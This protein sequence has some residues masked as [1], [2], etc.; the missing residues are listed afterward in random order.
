MRSKLTVVTLAVTLT[1]LAVVPGTAAPLAGPCVAG[2]SYDPA[3]DVNHDGVISVLD[4]QLAAGHWNQTG[5]WTSD[6][7]HDHLG[8]TWTGNGGS[9]LKLEGSFGAPDNAPVELSNSAGIGVRVVSAGGSGVHVVSASGGHGVSVGSAGVN[10]VYIHSTVFDGVAINSAGLDGVAINSAGDNGVRVEHAVHHGVLVNNPGWDGLFV[11]SAGDDGIHIA[12]ANDEGVYVG[13][14]GG[15]G[16][17]VHSAYYSGLVVNDAGNDG[18]YVREATNWAG[19]FIGNISVSG[20]C[21]GCRQANF[22]VNADERALQPGD[23][24]AVQA[25]TAAGFDATQFLW[26]VVPAQPGQA[27]VG[28][29]AGR[30][31]LV[32]EEWD[33][34][35][36]DPPAQPGQHLAPRAGAA[37]PGEY[38]AVVYSGP[39]QVRV[40]P[41]E[42][43]IAG[44]TRLTAAADGAVRPLATRTVD[45]MVVSEGAPVLGIALEPA[46]DGVVWVLVNPQ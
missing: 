3:C 46:K 10:G 7:D 44:G 9:G 45:G 13:T 1:L 35:Q 11:E 19:R 36:G 32:A 14:A 20:N 5:T 4:V 24:V 18:V 41:G 22:A 12:N 33:A 25:V 42:E 30:A 26:Q 2:A 43:A 31:E 17:Y 15:D 6:N 23:A 40:A 29:I 27:A 39:M 37:Q 38:L 28:V 8:Q 34:E 21:S 16:M